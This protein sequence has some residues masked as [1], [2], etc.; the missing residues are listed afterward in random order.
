MVPYAGPL[1]SVSL[2]RGRMSRKKDLIIEQMAAA[3]KHSG[4]FFSFN[5][6]F[7][8]LWRDALTKFPCNHILCGD[9]CIH[10]RNRIC[11]YYGILK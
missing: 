6:N 1:K 11:A 9:P 5:S 10:T 3:S 2:I 8:L 4:N 7:D